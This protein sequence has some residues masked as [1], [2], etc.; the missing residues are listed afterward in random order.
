[1]KAFLTAI[2]MFMSIAVIAQEPGAERQA[3]ASANTVWLDVRSAEEYA[4]GHID[5]A[6]NIPHTE[7]A[8]RIGELNLD[9][10]TPIAIYCKSGRRAG[11]AL[12]ALKELGYSDLS[13]EG[14]Y[15]QVK[16]KLNDKN[17]RQ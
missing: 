8:R 9:K 11:I 17:E 12:E 10:A 15:E 13:N 3:A 6:I 16:Q 5:G 1:M 4:Q 14:G 7:I 2:M